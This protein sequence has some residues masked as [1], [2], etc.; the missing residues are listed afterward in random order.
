M[1]WSEYMTV[2]EAAEAAGVTPGA[3]RKAIHAGKLATTQLGPLY[4]VHRESFEAW[5]A[6]DRKSRPNAGRPSKQ[7]N[8]EEG[9][10]NGESDDV[11][12]VRP[13]PVIT[14][15]RARMTV[16]D[17]PPPRLFDDLDAD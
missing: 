2:K 9:V 6:T 1:G 13:A 12:I 10:L 11:L 16:V 7:Q 3:I 5:Q 15:M 14:T 17:S 4:M 8:P